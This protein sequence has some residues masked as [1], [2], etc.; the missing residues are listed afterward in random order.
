MDQ[1]IRVNY[2]S[3]ALF[4]FPFFSSPPLIFYAFIVFIYDWDAAVDM[5]FTLL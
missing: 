5:N 3:S 2:T 4:L 1:T